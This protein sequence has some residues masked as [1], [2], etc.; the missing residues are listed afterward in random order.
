MMLSKRAEEIMR[1]L[2]HQNEMFITNKKIA[3]MLEI[4]ERSVNNYMKEVTDYCKDH[5]YYLMKKRGKGICLKMGEQAD[6]LR[7]TFSEKTLSFESREARINYMICTLIQNEAPYTVA[8]FA[9]ELLASKAAIRTD[10]KKAEE[11]S[12]KDHLEIRQTAGRGIE[13]IG[14]EFWKRKALV[15]RN[16]KVTLREDKSEEVIPD[17]RLEKECYSRMVSQ[18]RKRIVDGVLDCIQN[19]ESNIGFQFN[20]YT[21]A[22]MTEYISCQICRIR[23]ECVL[24]ETMI[25]RLTLVEEIAD[26]ADRL[27]R[28]LN[29]KFG[30]NIDPREGLYL[31]I[32][33]LGAEVQNSSRIANKKFLIEKEIQIEDVTNQMISYLSS[34]MGL[35]FSVDTL[36]QTSLALFLNSS[37]VRVKY[38]FEIKNP[39]LEEVKKTYS[40]IFSGCLTA[41]KEYENLVGEMPSEDEISYMAILFG[42]SMLQNEKKIN[43][44]VIG[45]GGI[46]ILQIVAQK[47]EMKIPQ[48]NVTSILSSDRALFIQEKQYDL[49]ITTV[50]TLKIKHS[51]VVYISLFVGEQDA[52]R[53]ERAC[54][55]IWEKD[56]YTSEQITIGNLLEDDLILLE[57]EVI[58]KEILLKKACDLLFKKKYVKEGFLESVLHREEISSSV[59]GGG[60]A[61]P[62]GVSDYV[63]HPA[64]V[65]IKTDH[66]VEWGGGAV[67][68][69]FLLAL[70]FEDIKSTRAFFSAFYEMTMYK[71]SAKFIR[72]GKTK[73]EIRQIIINNSK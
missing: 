67:D 37:L 43:A 5:G 64:V 50:P 46:G 40:A 54:H 8:L 17:L 68:V 7:K 16:Q 21:F 22:M 30:M 10:L 41:S 3:E 60:M 58:S 31:Y 47:I 25:N 45:S 44:A 38:G 6:R 59:L 29:Y 27:T 55:E 70:N 14:R 32:L 28:L 9:D 56:F 65:V 71:E 13:I 12:K 66:K 69:I 57:H 42:G 63:L 52:Y 49:V 2:V 48:I 73:E 53:L 4:S 34:I 23:Q 19:L 26:W 33:L 1:I 20:D 61:V 24:E 35:D 39:Y 18:Y 62:H 11:E 36:L 15:A 72:N 51:H